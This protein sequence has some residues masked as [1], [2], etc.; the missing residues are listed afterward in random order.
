MEK[1]HVPVKCPMCGKELKVTKVV[2]MKDE[3]LNE[4]FDYYFCQC[5]K[6]KIGLEV[7]DFTHGTG[8]ITDNILI[9]VR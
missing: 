1:K 7:S 8:D 3:E 9:M 4:K 6:C 2:E 5:L